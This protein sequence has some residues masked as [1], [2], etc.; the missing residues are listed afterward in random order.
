MNAIGRFSGIFY[1]LNNY[2]HFQ[3]QG[4][5]ISTYYMIPCWWLSSTTFRTVPYLSST[6]TPLKKKHTQYLKFQRGSQV[7]ILNSANS[8]SRDAS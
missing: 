1:C 2:M 8:S 4:K 7:F 5:K 6:P 3:G